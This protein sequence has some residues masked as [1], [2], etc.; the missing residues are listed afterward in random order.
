MSIFYGFIFTVLSY[1]V[2]LFEF[3]QILLTVL[4]KVYK[5]FLHLS[6]GFVPIIF[7]QV[8]DTPEFV[9]YDWHCYL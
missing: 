1:V 2:S 3:H 4:L 8:S 9:F 5:K 7:E 6:N